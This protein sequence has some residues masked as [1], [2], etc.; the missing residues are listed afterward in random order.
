MQMTNRHGQSIGG[1]VRFR[2]PL[3]SEKQLDHALHLRL[4]GAAV[5]DNGALDLGG[6][7]FHHSDA[8]FDGSKDRHASGVSELQ[9]AAH[10]G[11]VEKVFDRDALRLAAP[12]DAGELAIDDREAIREGAGVARAN[13]AAE[14]QPM[15][16]TVGIDA[17]IA[18]PLGAGVDTEHS[19]ASE[20]SIS[21]S[22]IS[23]FDQTCWTS[24]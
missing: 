15:P 8:C 12:D 17:A 9:G 13:G 20:A 4:L 16:A 11:G 10:V 18:G 1:I 24:S 23:K 19:H 5:S 6:G 14:H 21:F 2:R 3:E 22:S 7:V